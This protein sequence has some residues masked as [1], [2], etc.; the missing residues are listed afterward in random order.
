[1]KLQDAIR[2]AAF[3]YQSLRQLSNEVWIF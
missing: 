3:R 1:M 2:K